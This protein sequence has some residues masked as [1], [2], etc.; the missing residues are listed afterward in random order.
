MNDEKIKKKYKK[1]I[2]LFYKYNKSYYDKNNSLIT[3]GEFDS[4]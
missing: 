4:L 2:V 3:D 1:K